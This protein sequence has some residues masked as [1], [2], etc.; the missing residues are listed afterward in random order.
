MHPYPEFDQLAVHRVEATEKRSWFWDKCYKD[1]IDCLLDQGWPLREDLIKADKFIIRFVE[2]AE[3]LKKKITPELILSELITFD[4]NEHQMSKFIYEL[5]GSDIGPEPAMERMVRRLVEIR[6]SSD[7]K[8]WWEESISP[9]LSD[10]LFLNL[11]K[12]CERYGSPRDE[13]PYPVHP[14][15][16]AHEREFFGMEAPLVLIPSQRD[17]RDEKTM[18]HAAVVIQRATSSGVEGLTSSP[19]VELA[20]EIALTTRATYHLSMEM[21]TFL[22]N[23]DREKKIRIFGDVT[24]IRLAMIERVRRRRIGTLL[25]YR[26]IPDFTDLE[27]YELYLHFFGYDIRSRGISLKRIMNI[28]SVFNIQ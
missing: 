2:K 26:L 25:K 14:R 17:P 24:D 28:S 8:I 15:R 7:V 6:I 20:S 9:P 22:L 5:W 11:P 13:I 1:L 18:E 19:E 16:T 21:A 27:Y 10:G 12:N 23:G 3:E 4:L